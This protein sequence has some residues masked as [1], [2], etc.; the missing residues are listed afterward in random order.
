MEEP[1]T[2]LFL[3]IKEKR[4]KRVPQSAHGTK[5]CKFQRY[6]ENYTLDKM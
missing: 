4:T 6:D 2:P 1:N 3:K 5:G